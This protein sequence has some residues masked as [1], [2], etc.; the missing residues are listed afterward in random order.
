MT[1]NVS[2][3]VVSELSPTRESRE[4]PN[5]IVYASD[6]ISDGGA[7]AQVRGVIDLGWIIVSG[8]PGRPGALRCTQAPLPPVTCSKDMLL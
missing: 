5:V 7:G 8:H 1:L 4:Q 3:M 2:V 6:V